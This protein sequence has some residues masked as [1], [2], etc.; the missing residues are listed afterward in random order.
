MRTLWGMM[1]A[2]SEAAPGGGAFSPPTNNQPPMSGVY[3]DYEAPVV[4]LGEDGQRQMRNMR[5]GMP[6]S[7]R[8]L[9]DAANKRA[10]GLRKKGTEFDFTELL[11]MEPDKGTTN[12]RNTTSD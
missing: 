10:D 6:S 12:V 8:A 11:K 1:R 3:P 5:W 4:V 7:K 2:G 9:L